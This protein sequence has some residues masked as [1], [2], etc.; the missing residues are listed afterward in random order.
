MLMLR[1]IL[2]KNPLPKSPAGLLGK[3]FQIGNVRGKA[4]KPP[5]P[6]AHIT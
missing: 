5:L 1:T 6:E 4:E 2:L 3:K